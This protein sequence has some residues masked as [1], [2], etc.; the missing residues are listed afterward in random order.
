MCPLPKLSNVDPYFKVIC[1]PTFKHCRKG[2]TLNLALEK[3]IRIIKKNINSKF[4]AFIKP[5]EIWDCLQFANC[6]NQLSTHSLG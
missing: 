6:A 5:R 1:V 3:R 4:G 2:K